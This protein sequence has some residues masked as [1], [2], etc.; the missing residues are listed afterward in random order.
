L[1][2]GDLRRNR[3]QSRLGSKTS[4]KQSAVKVTV[5]SIFLSPTNALVY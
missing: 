2:V 4:T 1:L 5:L 3:L